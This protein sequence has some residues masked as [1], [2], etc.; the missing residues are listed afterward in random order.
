MLIDPICWQRPDIP[1]APAPVRAEQSAPWVL[2]TLRAGKVVSFSTVDE[3]PNP[4]G[5]RDLRVDGVRSAVTVPLLVAGH[6][7]GAVGFNVLREERSWSSEIL[8]RL[9]VFATAF[10]N[11]LAR[12]E[13]DEALHKALDEVRRLRD[14]LHAENVYLRTEVKN[15]FGA[16]TIVG[17]SAA[18]RRVLDQV[19]QVATPIRPCCCSAKPA[20][21]RSSSPR[22]FT[23]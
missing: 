23:N 3:I 9:R 8:H 20:P 15:R 11:V 13:S 4:V 1:P 18:V 2:E 16:G 10:G 6:L 7:I 22:A 21:A 14:Q 12:R 5:S 19:E 17:Q